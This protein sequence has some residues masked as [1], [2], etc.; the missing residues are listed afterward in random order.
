MSR[1]YEAE[2]AAEQERLAQILPAIVAAVPPPTDAVFTLEKVEK[3]SLPHP[4]VITPKH[5]TESTGMYLDV[6]GAEQRGARCGWGG[7]T[8]KYKEHETMVTLFV[9]VP[10]HRDL[11]AVP[12]LGAY[13]TSIK[14]RAAEL[15]VQG[16]AF[17]LA[18]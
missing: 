1:D 18:Q 13:L 4:Y 17:P 8:L 7:C 16:F 15:G 2:R 3:I 14:D 10:Q 9:R 11:N 5:I 6:E 12:G